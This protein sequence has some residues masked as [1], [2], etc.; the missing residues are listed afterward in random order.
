MKK[1]WPPTGRSLASIK[2]TN[3]ARGRIVGKAQSRKNSERL[4][5]IGK[6]SV[7]RLQSSSP[8]LKTRFGQRITL[9]FFGSTFGQELLCHKASSYPVLS[10]S[11]ANALANSAG[12]LPRSGGGGR[13]FKSCHSDQHLAKLPV[14]SGTTS[15]TDTPIATWCFANTSANSSRNVMRPARSGFLSAAFV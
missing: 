12:P 4:D 9:V 11:L 15:G 8:N 14:P 10:S 2:N 6:T 13:R 5:K 1:K 7:G 3:A